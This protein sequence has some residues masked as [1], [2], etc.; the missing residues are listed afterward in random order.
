MNHLWPGSVLYHRKSFKF[1]KC[2]IILWQ[3]CSCQ[4]SLHSYWT[5]NIWTLRIYN[6]TL[7]SLIILWS[8]LK[9]LSMQF[10]D[11]I[12]Y[13]S[14]FFIFRLHHTWMVTN[15]SWN[16]YNIMNRKN[17]E[18]KFIKAELS[19]FHYHLIWKLSLLNC[20]LLLQ[21]NEKRNILQTKLNIGLLENWYEVRTTL[22]PGDEPCWEPE[23]RLPSAAASFGTVFSMWT[24]KYHFLY[25]NEITIY[26]LFPATPAV[27]KRSHLLAARISVSCRYIHF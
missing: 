18:M 2:S 4:K 9:I 5:S 13:L 14:D 22:Q 7:H 20:S 26:P 10:C 15:K 12:L 24:V 3:F 17:H 16:K 8:L 27:S 21:M 6:F 19:H 25:S 1:Y 11:S 23:T